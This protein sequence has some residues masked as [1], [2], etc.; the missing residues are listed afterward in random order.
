V[1]RT[2]AFF[3]APLLLAGC[4]RP[5]AEAGPNQAAVSG[6]ISSA[7]AQVKRCYRSPRVPSSARRIVTRLRVRYAAD[8]TLVGLPRIVSQS[9]VTPETQPWAGRMADAASLAVIRCAPVRL[10][11]ELY[12][13]GSYEMDLIFSPAVLA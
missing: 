3:A 9:S 4:A 12:V 7:A 1:T 2:I 5:V 6:A 11:A 13:G 10:P 8:G